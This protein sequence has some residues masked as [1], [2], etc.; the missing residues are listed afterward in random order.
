MSIPIISDHLIF[1]D[2]DLMSMLMM[3]LFAINYI[4]AAGGGKGCLIGK[5][6]RNQL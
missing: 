6:D 3:M 5:E 4:H 2:I 1:P